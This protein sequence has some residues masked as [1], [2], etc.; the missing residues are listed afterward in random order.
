MC[1][2]ELEAL[3]CDAVETSFRS[4]DVSVLE[5]LFALAVQPHLPGV[6]DLAHLAVDQ[7]P[8]SPPESLT[9]FLLA[10]GLDLG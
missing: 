7:L 2:E 6:D 4:F 1:F 3:L 8:S 10:R 5:Q 9:P